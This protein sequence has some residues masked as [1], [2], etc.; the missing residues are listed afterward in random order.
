MQWLRRLAWLALLLALLWHGVS[1]RSGNARP[2][3]LDL[4]WLRVQ[5]IEVWWALLLSAGVGALFAGAGLGFAWMRLRI[6]N[7]RYRKLIERLESEVHQ[8]R[9]LPLVG[10]VRAE[11][12]SVRP[13]AS[14]G[15]R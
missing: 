14:S 2:I 6:V 5:N 12:E 9:S 7:R 13:R 8:L 1:F 4:V 11:T 15:G 10:S 3:D